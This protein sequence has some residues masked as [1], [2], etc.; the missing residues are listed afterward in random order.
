ME[1]ISVELITEKLNDAHAHLFEVTNFDHDLNYQVR[2]VAHSV[3]TPPTVP[4]V[5]TGVLIMYLTQKSSFVVDDIPSGM[6]ELFSNI[7]FEHLCE[8]PSVNA[9]WNSTMA[10][11]KALP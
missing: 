1:T 9:E 3:F 6:L 10:A 4:L 11:Y 7:F 8:I 2:K 5:P